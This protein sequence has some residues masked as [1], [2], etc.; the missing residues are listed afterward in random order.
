[1]TTI[2][3]DIADIPRCE[4]AF[5]GPLRDALVSAILNGTKTITSC[6]LS[7]YPSDDDPTE[8]IGGYETVVDSS[9]A[10]VCVIRTTDIRICRLA[11]VDDAHAIAEGE[12]YTTAA[13]WRVE[14]E[15]FWNSDAYRNF[16]GALEL[17]DDTLVVLQEF[18]VDQRY[19]IRA[20][21]PYQQ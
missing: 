11:D 6:L 2:S 4:F 15:Q 19:P 10:I 3:P 12:G 13:Q 17:H 8:Q 5:P 16:Y 21:Q 1:M 7:E 14:H 20:L 9:D 18:I